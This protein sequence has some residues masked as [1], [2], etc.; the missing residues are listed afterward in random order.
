MGLRAADTEV[1]QVLALRS[2][3]PE[4]IRRVLDPRN[5]LTHAVAAHAIPLLGVDAVAA[6]AI[7]SLQ[8][9]AD[10]NTG[11]LVDTMLDTTQPPHVRRRIARILASCR[12][13]RA[14]DGLLM[15]VKD[16]DRY[17][18]RQSGRALLR[19]AARAEGVRVEPGAV[20]EAVLRE[21][22]QRPADLTLVFTL[23]AVILPREPIRSAYRAIRCGDRHLRG[24]ALE[25]LHTVLRPD[26]RGALWP[27]LDEAADGASDR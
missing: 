27:H 11:K 21:A 17:V 18:R 4:R 23:L 2:G 5:P 13:Q 6:D 3:N 12:S 25:Y 20:Y 16:P 9:I 19:V 1:L 7:R 22:A 24:T 26:V 15:G 10:Q 8:P 14:A